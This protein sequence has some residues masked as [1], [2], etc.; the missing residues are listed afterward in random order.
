MT[1][2]QP[3]T[4]ILT[5]HDDGILR[6]VMNRPEK[7]NALTVAMYSA[8]TDAVKTAQK[9]STVRVIVI[10]GAGGCFTSG[11]DLKDFLDS[12]PKDEN[13]PVFAF[14]AAM[15]RAEKPVVAAV[16][17][18]AVGI[19][20]TMLLHCD[21]VYAG[22]GTRFLMPFVNLGLCPEAGSSFL[23]PLL[24]GHR[25]AAELLLL[26]ETFSAEKAREAGLV[27]AVVDDAEVLN[28]AMAQARKLTAKPQASV[29]L[30][31]AM[32]KKANARIV[33]QTITEEARLLTERLM[34]PE[35]GE[36]FNAFFEHRK[37]DFSKFQ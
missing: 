4:D 35:A 30:T 32:L 6:I 33:A 36:A 20:V 25:R 10:C 31:K 9:D 27:N 14:M 23:L 37:P 1:P 5:E 22:A 16:S 28:Y 19:G 29:R 11:N 7:K 15:H 13:S 24:A 21:L 17:G 18:L 12:P 34:S 3:A 26:G 8:L 2:T